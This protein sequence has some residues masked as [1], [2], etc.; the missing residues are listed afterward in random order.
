MTPAKAKII[1]A[2]H[3]QAAR[4][5]KL[6]AYE[7]NQLSQARQVL[8][9]QR[10]SA[11][12][13]R[14]AKF[15]SGD[16]VRWKKGKTTGTVINEVPSQHRIGLG[17]VYQVQTNSGVRY[18]REK[19]L[20]VAF[21]EDLQNA[22]RRNSTKPGSSKL[23]TVQTMR[24]QNILIHLNQA[25]SMTSEHL[26]GLAKDLRNE[27]RNSVLLTTRDQNKIR[28]ALR[29]IDKEMQIRGS[30]SPSMVNPKKKPVLIYGQV[31]QIRAKKTQNHI[32]DDECKAHNH[33][34]FHDFSTKPKMY[35]LPD[36]SLLIKP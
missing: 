31:Q 22:G 10:K 33:Q 25:Q 34:Y 24:L 12:N 14:M 20:T 27:L 36:G 32:C 5:R 8:R 18:A 26:L 23:T 6:T 28:K 13:A 16:V 35:G 15:K 4:T 2:T 29:I 17:R 1:F 30:S 9:Q 3:M 21:I 19:E 7:L 11:M